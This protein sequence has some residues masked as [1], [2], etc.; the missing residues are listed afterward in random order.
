MAKFAC[1][2]WGFRDY[3]PALYF[4]AAAR[5]E[6]ENVEIGL[7]CFRPWHLSPSAGD[8]E[9]NALRRQAADEG[10]RIVAVAGEA[11]FTSPDKEAR[12]QRLESVKKQMQLTVQMGARVLR[13]FAGFVSE[14]E[15]RDETFQ[16]VRDALEEVADYAEHL[17]VIVAVENHGGVTKTGAQC[18]WLLHGLPEIVG[19][20]YDPANFRHS[21]EDPL[22]ALLVVENR[23][24]YTH[25]KDLKPSGE[26]WQH[27]AVGEGII[28]WQ[29]IVQ[30]VLDSGFEGYLAIE[31]EDTAD[32]ER[33]TRVSL[34][35]LK[36]FL[37][38]ASPSEEQ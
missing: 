2:G 37:E 11:D 32:V 26:Q 1:A 13:I 3:K 31:Y 25:W 19:L 36:R 6:L 29:P 12:A 7:D 20:N 23:V 5:L 22:A 8:A 21:G 10:V 38:S 33:G 34:E 9:I 15:V 27:C 16:W 28:A 14:M 18:R 4:A 30:E 24:V 35:N 17:G